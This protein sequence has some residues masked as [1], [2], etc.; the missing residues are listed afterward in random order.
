M[1]DL[2]KK[3]GL[4]WLDSG[5]HNQAFHLYTNKPIKKPSDLAGLKIRVFPAFIPFISALGA[6]P[7]NLPM[8]DIYSA[9]ERGNVDGFVM[10][11]FGFV[12][13]F[14]WH[15]VTKYVIDYDLYR[16][17]ANIL[18]NPKKWNQLPADV[19]QGIIDYKKTEIN[20]AAADW[21]GSV[22]NERWQ[23]LVDSGVKPIKFSLSD[24]ETFLNTAYDSAWKYVA[25]K[26]PDLAPKLKKMLVK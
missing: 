14:S 2:H 6:A 15:E 25:D 16:A 12:K 9:M 10:T 11:H 1:A 5:N 22:S 7:V 24:A 8:G 3:V 17:A 18:V 19:R 26:S 21:F 23:L 4:I 20:A 13:N